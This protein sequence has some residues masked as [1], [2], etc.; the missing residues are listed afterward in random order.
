MKNLIWILL[1]FLL[2]LAWACGDEPKEPQLKLLSSDS[3]AL[4]EISRSFQTESADYPHP[5]SI[6][7]PS[8]WKGSVRL[9]TVIDEKTGEKALAVGGLTLYIYEPAKIYDGIIYDSPMD[10]KLLDLKHVKEF[11][12]YACP[13]ACFKPEYIPIG[14]ESI[15]VEKID[16]EVP[17]FIKVFDESSKKKSWDTIGLMASHSWYFRKFV[18]HGLDINYFNVSLVDDSLVDVSNNQLEGQV[19][20]NM[21]IFST[22]PNLSHNKYTK[23]DWKLWGNNYYIVPNLQYNEIPIPEEILETEFWARN[24]ECFIGN[25]GYVAPK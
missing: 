3:I 8:T 17:G 13:D 7:N 23:F 16:P 6:S 1:P 22:Q 20:G 21:I 24:H 4:V 2:T 9:D 19:S 11:K 12:V 10:P 5:W 15:L 18:V 14:C 25:P